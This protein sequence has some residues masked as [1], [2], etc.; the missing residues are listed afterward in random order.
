[1]GLSLADQGFKHAQ[2]SATGRPPY[3]PG[4]LLRLYV[5]GY[6]NRVRSSRQLEKEAG[7]NLEVIWLMRKLKPDFKTIADFRKD[8]GA[9]IKGVCR[10]FTLLCRKL[11]LFGGELV[12]IDGSKFQAQNSKD[13]NFSQ[14][15]LR[16]LLEKIDAR[17]ESY[18]AELAEADKTEE[19]PKA[20]TAAKKSGALSLKKKLEALKDRQGLYK[21]LLAGGAF[22]MLN[23]QK[24]AQAG[25]TECVCRLLSVLRQARSRGH[26]TWN[27]QRQ[28]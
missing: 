10:Q 16:A 23:N 6:L 13:R 22:V 8:N 17:V 11:D 24:P 1:E 5:Y 26:R 3:N 18:L 25:C 28:L 2:I 12:A 20:D 4:D 27:N 9:A 14:K 21:E 7:R 15:K 19:P